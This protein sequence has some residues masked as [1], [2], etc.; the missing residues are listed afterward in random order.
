MSQ[1][2]FALSLIALLA[3]FLFLSE[4]TT[5]VGIIAAA[6]VLGIW[7]RL[8]QADRQHKQVMAALEAKKTAE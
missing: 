8:V 4:A 5:G 3:G 7:A 2:L 6:G 1:L